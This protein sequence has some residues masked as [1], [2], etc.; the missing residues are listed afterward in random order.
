MNLTVSGKTQVTVK[1]G[2]AVSFAA[3]IEVPPGTGSVTSVEWDFEGNGN[4]V[5][6]DFGSS[7]ATVDVMG[8][9]T[10]QKKGTYYAAVRVTSNR[11]GDAKTTYAQ[12]ANLGR[13]KVIVN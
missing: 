12:V 6:K 10:Y 7:K 9:R 13:V 2:Q 1:A 11:N 5:K 8:S 4:F 3:H